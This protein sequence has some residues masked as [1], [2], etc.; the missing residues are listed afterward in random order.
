[1]NP[2][3]TPMSDILYGFLDLLVNNNNALPITP[4]ETASFEETRV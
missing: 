3:P 2:P 4:S 1:M